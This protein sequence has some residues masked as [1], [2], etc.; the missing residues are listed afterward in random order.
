M[1]AIGVVVGAAIEAVIA[2]WAPA[3]IYLPVL[4]GF[5]KPLEGSSSSRWLLEGRGWYFL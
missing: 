2:T 4:A 5:V 3:I 1:R